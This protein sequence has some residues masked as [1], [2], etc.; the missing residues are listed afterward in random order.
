MTLKNWFVDDN[1]HITHDNIN[2]SL[3]NNTSLHFKYEIT[4]I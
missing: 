3:G 1:S 2:E 4:D